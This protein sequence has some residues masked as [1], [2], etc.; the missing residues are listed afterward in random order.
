[1]A[2]P[3][4]GVWTE[5]QVATPV[6]QSQVQLVTDPAQG[7]P[8]AQAFSETRLQHQKLVSNFSHTKQ[9]QGVASHRHQHAGLAPLCAMILEFQRR[10]KNAG[11]KRPDHNIKLG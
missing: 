8:I 11:Y 5:D 6:H 10:C 3:P 4:S 9:R 1:M 2:Q 7:A